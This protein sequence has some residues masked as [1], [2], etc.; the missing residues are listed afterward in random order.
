MPSTLLARAAELETMPPSSFTV[1]WS[2][3]FGLWRDRD[4]RL[5]WPSNPPVRRSE[6]GARAAVPGAGL[7]ARTATPG[8]AV[9]L[10]VAGCAP[11]SFPLMSSCRG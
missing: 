1:A 8:L 11:P 3:E 2:D 10:A 6:T 9:G 4:Q 7:E 5:P